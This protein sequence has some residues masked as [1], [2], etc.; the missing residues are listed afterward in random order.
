MFASAFYLVVDVARS[1]M[2]YANAGHPSPLHLRRRAGEVEPILS[3]GSL[4]PALGLFEEAAYGSCV[5]P[6]AP[7]DLVI[8]FTDGLF[9]VEGPDDE[10]YSQDRLLAAVRK[11]LAVGPAELFT[12]LLAETREFSVR[13]EFVDDVC[14]LGIEVAG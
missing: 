12:E 10:Y 3:N 5:C 11:R 13:K 6:I 2:S 4:G 14:L 1:Q 8:L 7:G 9:E